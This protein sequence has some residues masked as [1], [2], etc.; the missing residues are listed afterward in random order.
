MST[1]LLLALAVGLF[2]VALLQTGQ[3][4][5]AKGKRG[6]RR[7][8]SWLRSY[9]DPEDYRVLD[10]LM[11]QT[12]LGGTTQIDHVVLC[13]YG[14]FVIETKNMSGWIF[15]NAENAT[16]TQTLYRFKSRFQNPLRQNYGHVKVIQ[17]TLGLKAGQ[18]FNV[19]AFVGSAVPQTPM[20]K[21]V[22]WSKFEL[23]KLIERKRDI[24]FYPAQL[25]DLE[26]RILDASLPSNDQTRRAH[27]QSTRHRAD[28]RKANDMRCPRCRARLIERTNRRTGQAFLGCSRFPKCKGTLKA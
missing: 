3:R 27:I 20:P 26:Q 18:L 17:A 4:P 11:L 8:S 2:S 21:N 28:P 19:V 16:W 25:N 24:Q 7:V 22:V 6:E 23:L 1:F 5:I 12:P 14:I 10:D 9:L 13:R 15:G